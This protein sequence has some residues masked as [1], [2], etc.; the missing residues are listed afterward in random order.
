MSLHSLGRRMDA[1][2]ELIRGTD[3]MHYVWRHIGETAE[4]AIER[5][6]M[7]GC[8]VA[9]IGWLDPPPVADHLSAKPLP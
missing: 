7:Q 6:G 2:E 9:V 1:L 4:Q 5:T 3:R 8:K